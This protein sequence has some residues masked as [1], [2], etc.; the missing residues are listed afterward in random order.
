MAV[1]S[2]KVVRL[3]VQQDGDRYVFGERTRFHETDPDVFDCSELI[4]WVCGRLGVEP[5]MPDGSWIQAKHCKNHDTLIEIDKGVDTAGALLFRFS[6][7]PFGSD[8]PD[9]AHVASHSA[10][11]ERWK[12]GRHRSVSGS[13]LTLL[14]GPGP[15]PARF[16]ASSMALHPKLSRMTVTS[17][18]GTTNP[19]S[20][21]SLCG[22]RSLR[23][24]S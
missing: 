7:N 20:S 23:Q 18:L 8:R 13:S 1:Q 3:A 4:Q 15:M 17:Y 9:R 16:R 5:E 21:T 12:P 19:I 24:A 10:T 14:T 2:G 6:S 11:A 22:R